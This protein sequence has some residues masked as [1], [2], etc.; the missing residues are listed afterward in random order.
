M[1]YTVNYY[2]LATLIRDAGLYLPRWIQQAR[3]PR[4]TD[5]QLNQFVEADIAALGDQLATDQEQRVE[6]SAGSEI[7]TASMEP[8]W[9]VQRGQLGP[10]L[11]FSPSP[12]PPPREG[13]PEVLAG[14]GGDFQTL[15]E[16]IQDDGVHSGWAD[17]LRSELDRRQ[18]D[19][20][21]AYA[22]TILTRWESEGHDLAEAPR[23]V[24]RAGSRYP[25]SVGST[26]SGPRDQTPARRQD[27]SA[28]YQAPDTDAEPQEGALPEPIPVLNTPPE[29]EAEAEW[30]K[31]AEDLR[32]D[33][34]RP[35]WESWIKPLRGHS[36]AGDH[37]LILAPDNFTATMITERMD[38][39]IDSRSITVC[40][41]SEGL[42]LTEAAGR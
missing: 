11:P 28:P 3:P 30:E 38:H 5:I 12:H 31:I 13:A 6:L 42:D 34:T 35:S 24:Q 32:G 10:F 21:P 17:E 18:P 37:L 39:L 4:G 41:A 40:V 16:Q 8:S 26:S 2:T 23:E 22:A 20:P 9:P 15:L 33:I 19:Y 25:R 36:Y 29:P 1:I 27:V 14:G 7:G